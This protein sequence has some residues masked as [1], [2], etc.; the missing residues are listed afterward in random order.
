MVLCVFWVVQAGL[1]QGFLKFPQAMLYSCRYAVLMKIS[2][3]HE[4][5][6][7]FVSV[8]YPATIYWGYFWF[9]QT[10]FWKQ[11]LI[12]DNIVVVTVEDNSIV[13]FSSSNLLSDS[14]QN[15]LCL[16]S[17]VFSNSFSWFMICLILM[18]KEDC[19]IFIIPQQSF[20]YFAS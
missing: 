11:R 12:G 16:D 19:S 18:H 6:Q 14:S 4:D 2:C 13:W 17:S 9:S 3:T 7:Y 10:I 5:K 20:H 1:Y 8:S 15:N